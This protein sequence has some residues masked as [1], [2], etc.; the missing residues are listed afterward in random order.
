[1]PP[2][3]TPDL[4]LHT[5]AK[6]RY[7]LESPVCTNP[8]CLEHHTGAPADQ[9][10]AQIGRTKV[11]TPSQVEAWLS[12]A[13][14][15][16]VLAV[17]RLK[18][19]RDPASEHA[20][21]LLDRAL[22]HARAIGMLWTPLLDSVT[23]LAPNPEHPVLLRWRAILLMDLMRVGDANDISR[24]LTFRSHFLVSGIARN[25]PHLSSDHVWRLYRRGYADHLSENLLL[26]ETAAA[27]LINRLIDEAI[28]G[29]DASREQRLSVG[30]D[31]QQL[32]RLNQQ[33]FPLPANR[34][35]LLASR[36]PKLKRELYRPVYEDLQKLVLRNLR[37]AMSAM[38]PRQRTDAIGLLLSADEGDR[39]QALVAI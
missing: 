1:M 38:T 39:T 7:T 8:D 5:A 30:W 22:D 3:T 29:R 24:L 36:L 19:F 11:A 6:P 21:A 31:V 15:Q 33:G 12:H 37:T 26:S 16:V 9:V 20:P 34:V 27:S 13:D 18:R 17:L 4:E 2:M 10:I 32:D 14:D 23:D 25:A 35:S 28:L